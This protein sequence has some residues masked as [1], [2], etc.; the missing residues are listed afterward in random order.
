VLARS[1][2]GVRRGL[3][4]ATVIAVLLSG[5]RAC[6]THAVTR[7]RRS[8]HRGTTRGARSAAVACL[9][10]I[11]AGSRCCW[12]RR[13]AGAASGADTERLARAPAWVRVEPNGHERIALE[14]DATRRAVY[15]EGSDRHPRSGCRVAAFRRGAA[16]SGTEDCS[17]DAPMAASRRPLVGPARARPDPGGGETGRVRPAPV[18]RSTSGSPRK[19]KSSQC[20][21]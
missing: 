18:R 2:K 15:G 19:S 3:S 7:G 4:V 14:R 16:R 1:T 6:S 13:S 11:A 10:T 17:M 12:R 5:K 20:L 21:L 8:S 9:G